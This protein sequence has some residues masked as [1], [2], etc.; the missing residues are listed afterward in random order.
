MG[1]RV[2]RAHADGVG[3]K[4]GNDPFK[5]VQRKGGDFCLVTA[6]VFGLIF[7]YHSTAQD[8]PPSGDTTIRA[9][10]GDSE[11]VIT[12]TARLAGAIHSL[13][14]NGREFVNSSDHGRQIQSASNFD[15]GT[16]FTPETFNPTEAGSVQD[17]AGPKSS[18]RLLHLVAKGHELQTTNQMAFWL[19][20]DGQSQGHPAKNSTMLSDHLL[21][22]RVRIGYKQL[23]HVIQYDVTFSVPVGEKHSYAQFE[24]V[25]GYMPAEFETFWKFNPQSRELE[26][27]DDGPG[28]QPHPVVLATASGSHAMGVFSPD[29]PSRGFENAGYGRFRFRN[30]KVVK[31]NCVFRL[32]DETNGI[33][34]GN[35]SFRNFV[36]VGELA[37]V[38]A[39]LIELHREFADIEPAK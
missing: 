12:T 5:T 38:K 14:W 22:K 25:T 31:W 2:D 36:V 9:K 3:A 10:A 33:A 34:P 20:P 37:T 7:V 26:P 19:T 6:F 4:R 1:Q 18:S 11:I 29:Q 28:E 35:Y 32:R 15:A 8:S 24:A 21:T 27:L 39:S 13:T 17:G 16:P 30:E 23:P